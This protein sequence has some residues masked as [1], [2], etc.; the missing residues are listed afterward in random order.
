MKTKIIKNNLPKFLVNDTETGGLVPGKNALLTAAFILLDSEL[1]EIDH[2]E[3]KFKTGKK[4][5]DPEA[6]AVNK[7]ILTEHNK[8]ALTNKKA[9]I[10]FN[11]W[12]K[13]YFKKPPHFL[14]KMIPIGHNFSF[15]YGF[16]RANFPEIDLHPF[17]SHNPIDTCS[18][19][20]FMKL[21]GILPK[22]FNASLTS[23]AKKAGIEDTSQAHNALVDSRLCIK[24]LKWQQKEIERFYNAKQS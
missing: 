23:I 11:D 17:I 6:L 24:V 9:A 3:L 21:L 15:D 14:D 1:N 20:Q 16:L 19:V 7:I 10:V 5:V 13:K 2:L 8:T 4:K 12:L 22:N 18:N